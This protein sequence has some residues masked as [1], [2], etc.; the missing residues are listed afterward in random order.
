MLCFQYLQINSEVEMLSSF[1]GCQIYLLLLSFN[2]DGIKVLL[3]LLF[4]RLSPLT[5]FETAA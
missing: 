3:F 1:S 4:E 2:L 5:L